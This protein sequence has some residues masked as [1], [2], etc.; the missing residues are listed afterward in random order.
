MGE[1]SS[2]RTKPV[3]VGLLQFG[4]PDPA[5]LNQSLPVVSELFTN[6]GSRIF[7]YIVSLHHKQ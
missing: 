4:Y 6:L 7:I 1:G 2:W 5:I 3:P